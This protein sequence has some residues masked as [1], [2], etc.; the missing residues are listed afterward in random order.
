MDTYNTLKFAP[1][2]TRFTTKQT[3]A[4]EQAFAIHPYPSKCTV[5]ELTLETLL[6]EKQIRTWF[7][8][9]RVK[10]KN[11]KGELSPSTSELI[12]RYP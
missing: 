6:K 1:P 3:L 8:D 5:K 12:I 10:M 7:C 2:R 11:K 9:K 4:L